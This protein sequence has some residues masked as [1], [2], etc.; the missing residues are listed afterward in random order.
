MADNALGPKKF[1][2]KVPILRN[3]W[4][5]SAL[6]LLNAAGTQGFRMKEIVENSGT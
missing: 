6:P 4:P 5:N 2:I 1:P 3:Q